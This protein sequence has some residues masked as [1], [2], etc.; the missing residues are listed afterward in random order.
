VRERS[1]P[2][3]ILQGCL[4]GLSLSTA[5]GAQAAEVESAAAA[6]ALREI[7]V[8]A[9]RIPEPVDQVPASVATVSGG[10][11]RTRDSWDM[12][13]A[14]SL[15]SGVEA[16]AGGDAGPSSAVPSF[17]G[18]H[19]FDA[20]LLV[21]DQVPWGGAFNPAITTL[22]LNDVERIEVLKGA[23]PVMY[24]ATSFVGVVH[25]L[26]YP[27][28]E[29]SDEASVA[30]GS[31]G[32][33]RGAAAFALPQIGGYKQS[34]AADGENRGFAD[35]REKVSDGRLLYR[36]A[37]DLG[38][39]ELRVDA[40]LSVVRDAPPSPVIRAGSAL[41]DLTPINANFNP[42]DA[43]LD[44]S[45]YQLAL[46]YTRPTPWGT[47]E[48]LASFSRSHVDDIRAF[49]HPDLSGSADTQNQ[50]RT[51]LDD[52]FDTHLA[53]DLDPVSIVVGAD[54][55]YGY[56]RQVTLNGNSAYTVPL[57]GSVVPPPTT[58]LPVDEVGFVA[59]RRLFAGQYVQLDWKPDARWDLLVGVRLNETSESKLASDLTLPPFTP[60]EQYDAQRASRN[61]TRPT[62]T[63]GL[64]Y[65]A[66]AEGKD[67][68]IVY[69]DFRNA[70][71]PA[72][73]DFGPDYQPAVLLP[74]TARSYEAGLKGVAADGRLTWQAEAFRLDFTNLVVS[75]ESGFLTNAGG[76]R[77]QGVELEARGAIGADLTLAANYS[78]H[79]ARFTQYQFFDADAGAY[80]NVA[81]DELP[82]SP[83]QLISAG[84]LYRP[85]QGFGATLALTY[86]GRRYLD[87]ENIAPVGGYTRLDA[88]L[89]Y[90]VGHYELTL[91][92][93][94]LTNQRPP[95]SAS[96]FG[97]E[98]F[99]LLNART[100]WLR[101]TYRKLQG[102]RAD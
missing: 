72:A 80:V 12:A 5:P 93:T 26:H 78:Y 102:G 62:E 19:E 57:D 35:G 50:N 75:T 52:Y 23:G 59:D 51:L 66:W 10:E 85:P 63:A 16:P 69:A 36:G 11:L 49:L 46:G 73:L 98:S 18:L 71:K 91:V 28:G 76:E 41:T 13:A 70:F 3:W 84:V 37:L 6:S 34:L 8:T 81:G 22:N 21:M 48:T 101:L 58:Q 87:E 56:G 55:L 92:G 86:V 79:E 29:A 88:T 61:V 1:V 4:L 74:E 54:L 25:V 14:L 27:A 65:R 45:K 38:T 39:G 20:F 83:R 67:E 82:L 42:S 2:P 68:L 15:V 7:T 60:T 96:E 43:A 53:R 90:C 24:G 97:S 100:L 94:N 9:T 31:Y 95:V 17:W 44:E 32:S 77:L 40:N 30:F 64:S 89:A 47:W 33:S 99:Y